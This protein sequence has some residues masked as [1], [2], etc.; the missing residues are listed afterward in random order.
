MP[1]VARYV[2]I[3]RERI[4]IDAHLRRQLHRCRRSLAERVGDA[5]VR[6]RLDASGDGEAGDQIEETV[7][8]AFR[9]WRRR[10]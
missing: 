2:R 5:E 1:S 8:I 4:G 6:D 7:D 10:G 9:N 3:S